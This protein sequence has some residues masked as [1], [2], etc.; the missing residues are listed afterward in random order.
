MRR[1]C[2]ALLALLAM[3]AAGGPPASTVPRGSPGVRPRPRVAARRFRRRGGSTSG[4]PERPNPEARRRAGVRGAPRG[5]GTGARTGPRPR[6]AG[7]GAT[8]LHLGAGPGA[9]LLE[10][11]AAG[12]GSGVWEPSPDSR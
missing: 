8:Q 2:A 3:L 6:A 9:P 12:P 7:A 1:P 10:G 5:R 4:P 11:P